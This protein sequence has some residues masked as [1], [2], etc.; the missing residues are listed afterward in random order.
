[1]LDCA[2]LADILARYYPDQQTRLVGLRP[3]DSE[4]FEVT[5]FFGDQH[6]EPEVVEV[7]LFDDEW[8]HKDYLV[9]QFAFGIAGKLRAEGRLHDGPRTMAVCAEQFE[10]EP[11]KLVVCPAHYEDF[12]GTCFALD[13][14]DDR[15][16]PGIGSLREYYNEKQ[17]DKGYPGHLVCPG[18][19]VCGVLM[20]GQREFR[21]VLVVRRTKH[22]ASLESSWGPSAAG[23]VDWRTDC[24]TL[25]KLAVAP[26]ADEV[27]EELGLSPDE[28]R[29]T[30][31]AMAR[32]ICRGDKPQL[33][34]LIQT[35][36]SLEDIT[37]RLAGR[38]ESG[39]E[40]DRWRWLHLSDEFG[41]AQDTGVELNH[42]ARMN[43][44]LLEEY[45]SW[46]G[47]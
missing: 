36:L 16:G 7:V 10:A 31:L 14:P 32:E 21:Q 37:E 15:F 20:I 11:P 30:P 27:T 39:G 42:E 29:I 1:M 34:C 4:Y 33:F 25:C 8:R 24:K 13:L 18:L 5:R 43:I 17:A 35:E 44:G 6:L 40:F 41:L 22:L 47:K 26:L 12:A 2:K 46:R 23:S 3:F 45:L 28:V 9:E 19:G 38:L